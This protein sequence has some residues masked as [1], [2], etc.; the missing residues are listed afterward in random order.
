LDESGFV[1]DRFCALQS[2]EDG[3]FSE[4]S[5]LREE[6]DELCREFRWNE[7]TPQYFDVYRRVDV[8]ATLDDLL[9]NV[10]DVVTALSSMHDPPIESAEVEGFIR[11][12]RHEASD[13][14][15]SL[16]EESAKVGAAATRLWTSSTALYA[17]GRFKAFCSIL[18]DAVREDKVE[19][20]ESGAMQVQKALSEQS[21]DCGGIPAGVPSTWDYCSY[22]GAG[23]P[24]DE[25]DFWR[26]LVEKRRCGAR[27][28]YRSR[29]PLA[30]SMNRTRAMCY[31]LRTSVVFR[32]VLFTFRFTPGMPCSSSTC[33][34]ID[35]STDALA[36]TEFLFAPYSVF[37]VL[38]VCEEGKI[39]NIDLA[40][41]T[42]SRVP[43][44]MCSPLWH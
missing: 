19:I 23:I 25:L 27:G 35:A 29:V 3:V 13:G 7:E 38:D 9:Q 33:R 31:C 8:P 22:R 34:T 16:A 1:L 21:G 20:L 36:E 42:G 17:S 40:V 12:L 39:V 14:L 32:K 24:D 10:Q 26:N 15:S 5:R 44:R 2:V 30:S 41:I 18:A 4:V 6:V 37:E 43:K 28:L 11:H